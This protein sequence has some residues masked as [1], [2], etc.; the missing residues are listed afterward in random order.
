MFMKEMGVEQ[1]DQALQLDTFCVY[2]KYADVFE[3]G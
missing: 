3:L 1:E 2:I